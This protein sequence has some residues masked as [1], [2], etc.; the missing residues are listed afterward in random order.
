MSWPIC[1]PPESLASRPAKGLG[2]C[3]RCSGE[4]T[5][6]MRAKLR[7]FYYVRG[8]NQQAFNESNHARKLWRWKLVSRSLSQHF[9]VFVATIKVSD[10]QCVFHLFLLNRLADL[11]AVQ[12]SRANWP[13][14]EL[15]S[16]SARRVQNKDSAYKLFVSKQILE[17]VCIF[18]H[19]RIMLYRSERFEHFVN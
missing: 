2:W 17:S 19:P 5:T 16:R 11:L 14:F 7:G 9:P 18:V 1:W 6:G 4:L 15:S 13:L 3:S 8:S 10:L 12:S